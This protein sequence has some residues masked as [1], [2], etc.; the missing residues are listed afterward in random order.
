MILGE[1]ARQLESLPRSDGVNVH[2]CT[3]PRRTTSEALGPVCERTI[4]AA[5][6]QCRQASPQQPTTHQAP[7][8]CLAGSFARGRIRQCKD[9]LQITLVDVD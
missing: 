3:N 1:N 9:G 2:A 6:M 5:N 8:C 7:I 4:W